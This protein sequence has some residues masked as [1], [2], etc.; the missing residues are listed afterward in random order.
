MKIVIVSVTFKVIQVVRTGLFCWSDM[1]SA[2][3]SRP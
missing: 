1:P 2:C 3:F